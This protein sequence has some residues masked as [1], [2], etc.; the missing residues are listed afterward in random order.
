MSD[1]LLMAILGILMMFFSRYGSVT[2][3]KVNAIDFLLASLG[4]IFLIIGI[5]GFTNEAYLALLNK[6]ESM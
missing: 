5:L 4:F 3:N 2:E 6:L 1:Y